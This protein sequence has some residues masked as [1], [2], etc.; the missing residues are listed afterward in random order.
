ML[1]SSMKSVSLSKSEWRKAVLIPR[2]LPVVGATPAVSSTTKTVL[3]L[4]SQV[5]VLSIDQVDDGPT[6]ALAGFGVVASDA[7]VAVGAIAD[8]MDAIDL[9]VVAAVAVAG[10]W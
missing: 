3:E 5:S 2:V 7:V 10:A 1:W 4:M 9:F 6:L 8:N